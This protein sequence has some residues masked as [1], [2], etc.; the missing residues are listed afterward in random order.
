MVTMRD[1]LADMAKA[2]DPCC[3]RPIDKQTFS[4]QDL[5]SDQATQGAAATHEDSVA[6]A[7]AT[8]GRPRCSNNISVAEQV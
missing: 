8:R 7:A 1:G 5:C 6:G 4:L 2:I 3:S